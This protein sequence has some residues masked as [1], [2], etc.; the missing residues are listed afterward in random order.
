MMNSIAAFRTEVENARV[1]DKEAASHDGCLD[2]FMMN[3]A[4]DL[5]G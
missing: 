4:T 1:F 2:A 5:P 3:I